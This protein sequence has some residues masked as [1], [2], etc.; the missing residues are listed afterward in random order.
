LQCRILSIWKQSWS[1]SYSWSGMA[2]PPQRRG[3]VSMVFFALLSCSSSWIF[4]RWC[5]LLFLWMRCASDSS[6]GGL[7]GVL[8]YMSCSLSSLRFSI[9]LMRVPSG[10][11]SVLCDGFVGCWVSSYLPVGF[12]SRSGLIGVVENVRLVDLHPSFVMGFSRGVLLLT[13]RG[14]CVFCL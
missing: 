9:V 14:T 13:Q 10:L 11:C 5:C 6:N 7:L 2:H 12:M 8:L 4:L 3:W 1:V